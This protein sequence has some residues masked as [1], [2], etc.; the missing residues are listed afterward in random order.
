MGV[1]LQGLASPRKINVNDLSGRVIA[2][3]AFNWIYQF[4]TTIRLADGSPLSDKNGKVTSHLNGIFYRSMNLLSANVVPW[5]IFD[6]S[7]PK[8]KQNTNLERQ[9]AKEHAA[10]LA[11]EAETEEERAMYLKRTVKVDDYIISSSKELLSLLGIPIYQAPAE[12]EAQAAGLNKDNIAYAV[13][14]QDYDT[15][16]FGGERIVRNLSITNKKK[17][18]GKGVTVTVSPEMIESRNIFSSLNINREQLITLALLI[19]TDYNSGVK[20][21]GP[22]K[23]LALVKKDPVEKILKSYD[24]DAEYPISEIF[25]YFM[26]PVVDKVSE[27]PVIKSVSKDKLIGFMCDDH[28]FGSDR[29]LSYLEK[30]NKPDNLLTDY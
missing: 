21:I 22:K 27:K 3:D 19:G 17:L 18:A 24:F 28:S 26:N 6:G 16:L 23:G 14:S 2:I 11:E 13:A 1:K 10:K 20:G 8:F 12:G 25:E 15:I 4:L 30:I 5:F 7:Y 9:K 29:I